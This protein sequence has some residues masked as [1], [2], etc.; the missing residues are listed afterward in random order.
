MALPGGV[1]LPL[2]IVTEE[3]T[4]YEVLSEVLEAPICDEWLVSAANDYLL[5]Q[6]VSGQILD[7][8]S[9][10]TRTEDA[11]CLESHYSCIEMIGQ[12]KIEEN[13]HDYGEYDGKNR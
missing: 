5:E 1:E 3:W 4:Y 9:T 11:A 6:M 13:L 2:A 12:V 8:S 10:V 7:S